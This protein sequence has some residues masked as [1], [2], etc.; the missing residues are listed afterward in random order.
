[1][2]TRKVWIVTA[3]LCVLA[4]VVALLYTGS[5]RSLAAQ[6]HELRITAYFDCLMKWD[7]AK[8]SG[9]IPSDIKPP[10]GSEVCAR[11]K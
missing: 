9:R 2:Q 1:M 10:S 8:R 11:Y 4:A 5:Q 6:A 7:L 3:A